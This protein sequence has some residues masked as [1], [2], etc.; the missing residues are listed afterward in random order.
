MIHSFVGNPGSRLVLYGTFVVSFSR[1]IPA[2]CEQLGMEGDTLATP[3]FLGV[4]IGMAIVSCGI[5]VMYTSGKQ[6]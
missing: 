3:S 4:S 6:K 2:L 1:F 5:A